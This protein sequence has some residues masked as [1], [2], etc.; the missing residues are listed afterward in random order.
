MSSECSEFV[1]VDDDGLQGTNETIWRLNEVIHL[2]RSAH[3]ALVRSNILLQDQLRLALELVLQSVPPDTESNVEDLVKTVSESAYT[4]NEVTRLRRDY[5][6]SLCSK[7]VVINADFQ[8]LSQEFEALKMGNTSDTLS[9]VS[10]VRSVCILYCS[11][12]TTVMF[13]VAYIGSCT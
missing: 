7:L 3:D 6:K 4:S 9:K 2:Y 11:P 1:V 10:M 8:K 5:V 13:Y 12:R